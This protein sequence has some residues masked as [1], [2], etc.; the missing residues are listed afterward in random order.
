MVSAC[1]F[2][3]VPTE[4]G[5]LFVKKEFIKQNVI[6]SSVEMFFRIHTGDSGI[7]G[8]SATFESLVEGIYSRNE[9]QILRKKV[10]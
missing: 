10:Y 1:G 8:N 5:L 2:D 3:S 9:L 4:M 7:V 6:P